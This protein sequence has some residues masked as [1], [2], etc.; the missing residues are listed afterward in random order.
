MRSLVPAIIQKPKKLLRYRLF[1]NIIE[2]LMQSPLEPDIE[3]VILF[4]AALFYR[5][6][7]SLS[8]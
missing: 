7:F 6:G 5:A 4:L 2:Q 3:G 1:G 8:G